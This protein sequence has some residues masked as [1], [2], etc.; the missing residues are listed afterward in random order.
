MIR[1]CVVVLGLGVFSSC[2]GCGQTPPKEPPR[3]IGAA[4]DSDDQCGS[5]LCDTLPGAMKVCQTPCANGC[6]ST[7]VCVS[8]GV[9]R[10]ACAPEREGLC[11]PC[12]ADVDC[13]YPEDRCI[14]VGGINVCGRD[15]SFNGTCPDGYLCDNALT[16]EGTQAVA[17]CIPKS[18][19]CA[20]TPATQGQMV[21]CER[22]NSFGVCMGMSVCN[23]NAYSECSAHVPSVETCNGEDDDCNGSADDLGTTS[24]GVGEC[25]VTVPVCANGSMSTCLPKDGGTEICDEKDNDCDGTVDNG[26]DKQGSLTNCGTC[27]NLCSVANGTPACGAGNCRI[28]AC[29]TGFGDCN[30]M[31]ADGCETNTQ[32]SAM[33]CGS[34]GNNCNRPF[35]DGIC[36]NGSCSTACQPG[37]V[38]LNGDPSDGCEYLC[39]ATSTT[40]FPDLAFVDANCDG[41]DGEVANAI[42]VATGGS[43]GNAGTKAAPMRT[44]SAAVAAAV[45]GNKRDVYAAAGTYTEQLRLAAGKGVYGGYLANTWVRGSF[46]GVTVTGT[47]SPLFAQNA[48]D[49]VVQLFAFIGSTPVGN[50]QTA[51]GATILNSNRVVLETVSIRAGNGT[52]GTTGAAGAAGASGGNGQPGDPGVENSGIGC[53]SGNQPA[54]G[55][56]GTSSCSRP[57]GRGGTPGLGNNVG[58]SGVGGSIGTAPGPGTSARGGDWVPGAPFIGGTGTA[59][60]AGLDGTS[61][62]GFGSVNSLGYV[63]AAATGGGNGTHGNGGGGGGGGG[64]GDNFCDSYGGGGGG[65][66]AGGCGGLFGGAGMS[67]GASIALFLGGGSLTANNCTLQSGNGGSGGNGGTGGTFGIGG[68]PGQVASGAGSNYGGSSQQDDGSNG[69]RGGRGG[70]GGRGGHGGAGGG[71]PT[72]GVARAVGGTYASTNTTVTLGSVGVGGFSQVGSGTAGLSAALY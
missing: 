58:N 28:S 2:Q 38:D 20:C 23:A 25:A 29:N 71:G 40:D 36:T 24:C 70:N 5:G 46:N 13:P 16:Q 44:L 66:G 9:G 62:L 4:C 51:Y 3:V 31:Y 60:S 6:A 7:E 67:G 43:D 57:G 45:A 63:L 49:A 12:H 35:A 26:F 11:K 22:A 48:D 68:A 41:I 50:G 15:C 21:P 42:F 59:G 17:Q 10:F 32:T 54:G 18:G 47:N 52:Q 30:S 27:G 19:T 1:L 37:H 53:S 61:A 69:A 39:T 34:C 56:G 65:G 14:T 33:H 55:A 64:G 8:L 72:I